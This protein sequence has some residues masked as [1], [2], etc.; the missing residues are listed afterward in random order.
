MFRP[1][2]PER[3][4]YENVT[5]LM[6]DDDGTSISFLGL[7][8]SGEWKFEYCEP[9]IDSKFEFSAT[10]NKNPAE[11]S[12]PP[13][14]Y[15]IVAITPSSLAPIILSHPELDAD[16]LESKVRSKISDALLHWPLDKFFNTVKGTTVN[17]FQLDGGLSLKDVVEIVRKKRRTNG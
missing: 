3:P 6:V 16:Q 11:G 13:E 1:V 9:L 15:W 12:L 7:G 17:F 8:R 4:K 10:R 14:D 5:E 2:R